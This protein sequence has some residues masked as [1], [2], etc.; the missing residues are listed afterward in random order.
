MYAL[1]SIRFM[2]DRDRTSRN[3]VEQNYKKK[4]W[5]HC[6]CQTSHN[7]TLITL[8]KSIFEKNVT[9]TKSFTRA[10]HCFIQFPSQINWNECMFLTKS[11]TQ[12]L[13]HQ[14][15]AKLKKKT[16][17]RNSLFFMHT[18]LWFFSNERRKQLMFY[19]ANIGV[20]AHSRRFYANANNSSDGV[21]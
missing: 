10:M 12:N 17:L 20:K 14:F 3:E 18:A 9:E 19:H 16:K 6:G 5:K 8:N 15:K 1:T 7:T 4:E 2:F 11:P 13:N 21:N